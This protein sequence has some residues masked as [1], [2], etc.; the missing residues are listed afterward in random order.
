[1]KKI[2]I[3]LL[4]L[5]FPVGLGFGTELESS[6]LRNPFDFG[7]GSAGK[8]TFGCKAVSRLGMVVDAGGNRVAYIDNVPHKV[9]DMVDGARI[10]DI[11]LKYVVMVSPKKTWRL[12]V[13]PFKENE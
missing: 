10:T 4:L 3:G 13:E 12:Y 5:I 1:M 9:G 2:I 8:G 7:A 11:T 6:K